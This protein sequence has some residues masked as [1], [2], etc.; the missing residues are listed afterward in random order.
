MDFL[1]KEIIMEQK[2]TIK[3]L[4]K[5][6]N[7]IRLVAKVSSTD[8]LFLDGTIEDLRKSRIALFHNME[9]I[10]KYSKEILD[11]LEGCNCNN[12][13]CGKD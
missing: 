10:E 7:N 5:A 2:E 11:E 9:D 13:T 4:K 8:N 1:R 6:L 12:C 3:V